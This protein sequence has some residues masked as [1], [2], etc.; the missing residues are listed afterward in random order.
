MER[1][2]VATFTGETEPRSIAETAVARTGTGD[3]AAWRRRHS[4]A[5][6]RTRTTGRSVTLPHARENVVKGRSGTARATCFGKRPASSASPSGAGGGA[7]RV[8]VQGRPDRVI[9]RS[10]RPWPGGRGSGAGELVVG[11]PLHSTRELWLASAVEALRPALREH[12]GLSVPRV[13]VSCGVPSRRRRG[14]VYIGATVDDVAEVT[15][16]LLHTA[17]A[18]SVLGTLMRLCIYVATGSQAHGR[19]FQ[20][21]ARQCGLVPLE[22]TWATAGYPDAAAVPS[23]VRPVLKQLGPWPAPRLQLE[24]REKKQSSRWI[25]VVCEECSF[26]WRSSALHLTQAP[27]RCPRQH[28]HGEQVI[29]WPDDTDS[30]PDTE[31]PGVTF[32]SAKHGG[33]SCN[34]PGWFVGKVIS[35]RQARRVFNALCGLPDCRCRV[36]APSSAAWKRSRSACPLGPAVRSPSGSAVAREEHAAL[37]AGRRAGGPQAGGSPGRR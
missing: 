10:F 25:T 11:V 33:K 19:G 8:Q 12:A 34:R 1:P 27:I 26:R 7:H 36:F 2:A 23:W 13:R 22:G 6:G 16:S 24:A 31:G 17:E 37:E 30:T 3:S 18:S 20:R 15:L 32:T 21:I 35:E 28:C 29:Q 14:E 4:G 5:A 9:T